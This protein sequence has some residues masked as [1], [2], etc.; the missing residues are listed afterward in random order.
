MTLKKL[1]KAKHEQLIRVGRSIIYLNK[2]KNKIAPNTSQRPMGNHIL[3]NQNF[4]AYITYVRNQYR[5]YIILN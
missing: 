4:K 5:N 3:V 1:V 2:S